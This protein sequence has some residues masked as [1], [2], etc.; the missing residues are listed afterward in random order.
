MLPTTAERVEI[1]TDCEINRRIRERT[2]AHVA[3]YRSP[4]DIAKRLAELDREWDVE[5][6]IEANASSIMLAGLGLGFLVEKRF[7]VIPAAVAGFLLQHA[8]QGWCP[9]IPILRR[10][11]FRTQSEIAEERYALKAMRGDFDV[12]KTPSAVLAAVRG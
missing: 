9:P 10:M 4:V 5:R 11:G 12:A 7:L 3:F 6:T 8:V 2:A 1:N